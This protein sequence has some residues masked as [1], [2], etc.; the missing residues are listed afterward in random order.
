MK[1]K[2]NRR[3]LLLIAALVIL[4][5]ACILGDRLLSR[6]SRIEHATRV[7]DLISVRDEVLRYQYETGELPKSLDLLVPVYLRSDQIEHNGQ[8]MYVYDPNARTI[9]LAYSTAMRGLTSRTLPSP[10]LDLPA[11]QTQQAHAVV[12]PEKP[13]PD[14]PA[15]KPDQTVNDELIVPRSI[16]SP[17]PPLGAY[18]FEAEMYSQMN[19]GWEVR[20]DPTAA[21]G[22]YIHSK[23][24][25]GNGPGQVDRAIYNFYDI[26]EGNEYNV[27]KYYFHLPKA[28]RY[29]I[30]GRFWTTGSH[31][32][33]NVNVG[34]DKGG[35][36][37][38]RGC[39]YYGEAMVN[40]TPFR[41]LWTMA[42]QK[43]QYL[44]AGDHY[45]HLYLHEDGERL[46]QIMLS[47]TR[48][49]GS[50][51]Y[52]A[53]LEVERN[54]EFVKTAPEVDLSFDLKTMVMT[55][56][57]PPDA[58]LALRKHRA[59][60]GKADL[61][62]QIAEPNVVL[63]RYKVDLDVL[64]PLSFFPI[65]FSALDLSNLPRREYLLQASLLLDGKTLANCHVP[66][67]HPFRW[68]IAGPFDYIRGRRSGPLDGDASSDKW[69]TMK[70]G[71]WD[72]FGVIDFGLQLSGKSLHAPQLVTAYARTR[73]KVPETKAYL[74]KIQS[75]D[76]MLL[77][78]DGKQVYFHDYHGP[79]TRSVKR[80]KLELTE[81]EHEVRMRVNQ[82]KFS[83]YG[84]G[85]WQA[86]LRFRTQD[87]R[88]SKVTG[89]Y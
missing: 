16:P 23:E 19:Y 37:P 89:A 36:I 21:G 44:E 13:K 52:A 51:V 65:D 62:L 12:E 74:L 26:Q 55:E 22:T 57:M 33:N 30:Y 49:T 4:V 48:I 17:E 54:T 18:V 25:V 3:L 39:R 61:V 10:V 34:V 56:T 1:Q 60:E 82:G 59:I 67:M 88:L 32:S 29:Y 87:D 14:Q 43:A 64:P 15:T 77:W 45:L 69:Q 81:G 79:V 11:P 50:N 5:A 68:E 66:L 20:P 28:G 24:G 76:Q 75:D 41:W 46:D 83:S 35:P 86:S 8:A 31:C 70:E 42:G 47:P 73:I 2:R 63:G 53:N 58:N 7:R 38:G 40:R 80:L 9:A 72:H 27:L 85:R 84:D 71:S 78:I 6:P